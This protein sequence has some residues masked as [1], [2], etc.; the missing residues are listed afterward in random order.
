MKRKVGGILLAVI[1]ALVGT[2]AL[3]AYVNQAKE[4]AV[5]DV[6]P[7]DVLVFT[8]SVPEGA[9]LSVI[10]DSVAL[11]G[12]PPDIVSDSALT[13]LEGLDPTLV[14]GIAF[15]PGDQLLRSRL[16]SPESLVRIDVP[17]GLQELTVA[18]D[19]ERAVGGALQPGQ[20]VGIIMSFDPFDVASAGTPQ[21]QEGIDPAVTTTLPT[22]TPNTTHLTLQQVLITSVQI[23]ARDSDRKTEAEDETTTEDGESTEVVNEAPGDQLLV[24]FAVS[25]TEAEQIVFAA[26]FGYIWLTRQNDATDPDPTRIITLDQVYVTVPNE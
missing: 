6:E 21:P 22:R 12:V 13:T 19:P 8:E 1:L 25:S 24:T 4:D 11:T 2:I 17:D 14:A 15:E 5:E 23:S 3:V 26:E 18:L 16:V 20:Y 7:V 9:T 10:E